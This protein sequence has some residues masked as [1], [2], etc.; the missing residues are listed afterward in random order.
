MR[1]IHTKYLFVNLLEN[2]DCD[3]V[4]DV[5]SRDG[6]ESLIFKKAHR[7]AKVVAFEANPY[8]FRSILQDREIEGSS[9]EVANCAVW[10]ENGHVPFNITE[11][12]DNL[13]TS[14]ILRSPEL[15]VRETVVIP[16]TRI[17]TFLA[18][19]YSESRRVAV[20]MDIEG[21]E[22]QA[23]E[24]ISGCPDRVLM[25]HVETSKV[26]M[27]EGQ[28]VFAEINAQ[29]ATFGFEPVGSNFD[30]RFW[31]DVLYVKKD[32]WSRR[33]R[34]ARRAYVIARLMRVFP[35]RRIAA[36]LSKNLPWLHQRLK[37]RFRSSPGLSGY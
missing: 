29:L 21:A 26:P 15:A 34:F 20:W 17:D 6:Q 16:S 2:L 30:G 10:N 37:R 28:K 31:G 14:S 13:G 7:E 1:E 4:L 19:R 27:R 3:L 12:L 36:F 5:G 25:I 23:L 33:D 22:Y 24:G 9:V 35:R 11:S 18:N 32:V 8:N